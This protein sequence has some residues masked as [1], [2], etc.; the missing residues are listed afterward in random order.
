MFFF[1]NIS[2]CI[3]GRESSPSGS[4]TLDLLCS[5]PEPQPSRVGCGPS[6]MPWAHAS[7]PARG[8]AHLVYH[9]GCGQRNE[10]GL[11]IP[12]ALPP[13]DSCIPVLSAKRILKFCFESHGQSSLWLRPR[14]LAAGCGSS[15]DLLSPCWL[16]MQPPLAEMEM[17]GGR[18]CFPPKEE[19]AE[20][21]ASE[22]HLEVLRVRFEGS[23]RPGSVWQKLL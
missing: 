19:P 20:N 4:N 5:Q 8:I 18:E 15:R 13:T 1:H 23:S 14:R 9:E 12:D 6:P 17:P 11:N 22:L 21:P 7:S 16:P 2:L 3:S 10:P